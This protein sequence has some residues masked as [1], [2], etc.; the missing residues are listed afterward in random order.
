[1][2][3]FWLSKRLHG[4]FTLCAALRVCFNDEGAMKTDFKGLIT[5]LLSTPFRFAAFAFVLGFSV[6]TIQLLWRFLFRHEQ[7][8]LQQ[9]LW[10]AVGGLLVAIFVYLSYK[11]VIN[12]MK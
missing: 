5:K 3:A 9:I 1:M 12:R 8:Q 7:V 6:S 10:G 2:V 4:I 11:I